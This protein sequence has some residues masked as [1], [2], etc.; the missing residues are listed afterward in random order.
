MKIMPWLFRIIVGAYMVLVLGL[1]FAQFP[2]FDDLVPKYLVET[3][4]PSGSIRFYLDNLNGR[5]SSISLFL[6]IGSSTFLMQHYSLV[7]LVFNLVSLWMLYI[8]VKWALQT[9]FV[10]NNSMLMDVSVTLTLYLVFFTSVPQPSSFAYWLATM[11]TY[12]LPFFIFLLLVKQH[13]T[14]LISRKKSFSSIL[15]C[16]LLTIVLAGTNEFIGMMVLAVPSCALLLFV[17]HQKKIPGYLFVSIGVAIIAIVCTV[18][19]PG[20]AERTGQYT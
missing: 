15:I 17:I 16:C 18:A 6:L 10:L 13:G 19:L 7:L 5:Y 8:F 4:G 1:V 12:T 2:S 11:V 14:L 20:N 9:F 3:F